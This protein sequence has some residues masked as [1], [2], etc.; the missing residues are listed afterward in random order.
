[1]TIKGLVCLTLTHLQVLFLL[2]DAVSISDHTV[3][4]V[5]CLMNWEG[6]GR[7][8]SWPNPWKYL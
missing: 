3:P 4:L 7:K 5:G 1:M 6:L 2:N 8:Y